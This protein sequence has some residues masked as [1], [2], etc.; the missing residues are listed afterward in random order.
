VASGLS[1]EETRKLWLRIL[2]NEPLR[3]G[4]VQPNYATRAMGDVS[5]WFLV[6]GIP[7]LSFAIAIRHGGEKF[8]SLLPACGTGQLS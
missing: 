1:T 7:K 2:A 4:L 3:K 8:P 6:E 5:D